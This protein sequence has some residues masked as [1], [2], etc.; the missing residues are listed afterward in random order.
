MRAPR[1]V[2]L[3]AIGAALRA[4]VEKARITLD[5][6]ETEVAQLS[7]GKVGKVRIGAGP[8]WVRLVSRSIFPRFIV[9]RPA[10]QVQFHV[11]FNTELFELVDGGKLDFAVCG[12]LDTQPP[13]LVFHELLGTGLVVVVRIGHPLTAIR[14]PAIRDLA[15]FRAAAPGNTMRARLI[16]EERFA[17][18]G[19]R[20]HPHAIETNSWEAI[21]DAVATTD[22]YSLAPRHMALWHG[23]ASRLVAINIPELDIS[24]RIGVV[25]RADAYL[26][27]LAERAIELI[28][29]SLAE[30]RPTNPCGGSS[31][32]SGREPRHGVD[33]IPTRR[34]PW[35][36]TE[37]RSDAR[38]LTAWIFYDIGTHGYT[39]LI[40]G[41]RTRSI[42]RR[43][44]PPADRNSDLLW[45]IALGL[46][47]LVAGLFGPWLGALADSTGRRRAAAR[48][49]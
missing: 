21:L 32:A 47:L 18:L 12:L 35:R 20:S 39:L 40:S 44:S 4:R 6:A 15:E 1:G 10:A 13:N 43:T 26:S 23:W 38:P 17:T 45:A 28:K 24:Q 29:E 14:N 9:E 33:A 5:D 25:T 41:W 46:P 30:K 42:S 2:E 7:A 27:P 16:A 8:L 49:Q 22:L 11:A 36:A 19:I 34:N 37:F 3:T 48:W 31:R